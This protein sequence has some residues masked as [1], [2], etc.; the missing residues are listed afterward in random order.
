MDWP[1]T[2][3]AR[4]TA[5][6]VAASTSSG[7][8]ITVPTTANTK[9]G[10]AWAQ[11]IAATTH[12]ASAIYILFNGPTSRV[13]MDIGIG[14]SGSEQVLVPNIH[15]SAPSGGAFNPVA[16]LFPVY[17]PAGSRLSARMQGA[18]AS[19]TGSLIVHLLGMGW[20]QPVPRNRILDYGTTLGT[21]RGISVDP[22]ATANTKPATWTTI[23]ATTSTVAKG[24]IIGVG[25]QGNTAMSSANWLVDVAVGAASSE[26]AIITD[27]RIISTTGNHVLPLYSP[28]FP[29]S[30]P[31]GV[32]LSMRAQSSIIDATDRLLDFLLYT[33][34]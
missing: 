19:A 3:G 31:A 23:A 5:T 12:A 34:T 21:T 27:Y 13:L 2:S 1:P 7:T 9:T 11:L 28:V 6:G 16:A 24:I 22:G 10:A 4:M 8:T 17:V 14:A 20:D 29:V 15:S 26:Q 32:R 30:L 33:I 25:N 18:T